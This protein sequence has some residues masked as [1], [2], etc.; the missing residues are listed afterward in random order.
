MDM[1]DATDG[2]V[3]S[4]FVSDVKFEPRPPERLEPWYIDTTQQPEDYPDRSFEKSG[5]FGAVAGYIVLPIMAMA[6]VFICFP[7]GFH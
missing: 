4:N 3:R 1:H 7:H 2:T 5:L 6:F